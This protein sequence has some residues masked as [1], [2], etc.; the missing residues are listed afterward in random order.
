MNFTNHKI[1]DG[2]MSYEL[3]SKNNFIPNESP[4]ANNLNKNLISNMR[5]SQGI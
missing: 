1:S 2:S 4:D 3:S 5:N